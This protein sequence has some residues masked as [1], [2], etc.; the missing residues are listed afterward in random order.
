MLVK[1]AYARRNDAA[2]TSLLFLKTK[3]VRE[4]IMDLTEIRK[5][6]AVYKAWAQDPVDSELSQLA[7]K[8][9]QKL[10]TV[11]QAV[12][13]KDEQLR[14]FSPLA[15]GFLKP[16]QMVF[17][18]QQFTQGERD[19]LKLF[20]KVL[21]KNYGK[22]IFKY[23][24]FNDTVPAVK[25]FQNLARF[26]PKV[27]AGASQRR[28]ENLEKYFTPSVFKPDMG[29]FDQAVGLARRLMNLPRVVVNFEPAYVRGLFAAHASNVGYPYF[30]NE[31][32]KADEVSYRQIVVDKAKELL[33][34]HNS[35]K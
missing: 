29:T 5:R 6:L 8:N 18:G 19:F 22:P 14:P 16:H 27:T 20:A 1:G 24:G 13:C 21:H 12:W 31:M 26:S 2:S 7:V 35:A 32:S 3:H 11:M 34:K 33:K 15:K 9:A 30:A 28:Y 17:M 4:V 23:S 25:Q 10:N